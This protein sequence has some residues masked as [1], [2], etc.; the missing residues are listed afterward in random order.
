MDK[1][2]EREAES[3]NN[4]HWRPWEIQ[5]EDKIGQPSASVQVDAHGDYG[6]IALE[7]VSEFLERYLSLQDGGDERTRANMAE[8]LSRLAAME[9]HVK[10]LDKKE[11]MVLKKNRWKE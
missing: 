4:Y 7:C 3:Q 10:D 8:I 1:K 9:A 2:F 11:P 6:L 5:P